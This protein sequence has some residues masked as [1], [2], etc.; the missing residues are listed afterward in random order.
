MSAGI[1]VS[2]AGTDVVNDVYEEDGIYEG[3]PKYTKK[4][5]GKERIEHL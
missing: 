5:S 3:S 1:K 2:G 4:S